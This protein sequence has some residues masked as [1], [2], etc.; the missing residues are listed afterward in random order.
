MSVIPGQPLE[1][2]AI[3]A[4][5]TD[6]LKR[7]LAFQY[8]PDTVRLTLEPNTVGGRP[9]S[10]SQAVRFAGA[11]N[12][13]ITID[14]RFS[15]VDAI[16]AGDVGSGVAPQLAALAILTYPEVADVIAA[17]AMLELG[18]IEVLPMTADRLLFVWGGQRVVPVQILSA[19]IVEELYDRKLTP[20]LATVTLTLRTVSY[21]DVDLTNPSYAEFVGYQTTLETLAAQAFT[22]G[23]G[24]GDSG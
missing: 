15:A 21:S 22:H 3:V 24:L 11:A 5:S 4:V 10:R 16:D 17:Q 18:V 9:G 14:A 19:S 2:G 8:N 6:G 7:S 12:Q 20:V 23:A 13:T 1:R